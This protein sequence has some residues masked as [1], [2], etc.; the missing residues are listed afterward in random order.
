M[1]FS[2]LIIW[3]KATFF[4]EQLFSV[5]A[6]TWLGLCTIVSRPAVCRV[7]QIET[8]TNEIRDVIDGVKVPIKKPCPT[9]HE[10]IQS[11]INPYLASHNSASHLYPL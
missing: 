5:V 2:P 10:S 9:M 6:R 11:W 3:E 4:F 8:V 7:A 1:T